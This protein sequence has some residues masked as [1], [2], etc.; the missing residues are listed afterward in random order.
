MILEIQIPDETFEKYRAYRPA[1]PEGAISAH[2]KRFEDVRPHDRIIILDHQTRQSLEKLVGHIED[3]QELVN[4]VT[5]A[6]SLKVDGVNVVVDPELLW[7][8]EE[9]AR[10]E[11]LDKKDYM[12]QK[13]HEGISVAVRGYAE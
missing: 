10:F 2:L 7:H 4:R 8:I 11:G 12:L 13:I 3:A 9:Q 5:E 6:L 1:D